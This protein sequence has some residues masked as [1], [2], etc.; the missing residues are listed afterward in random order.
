MFPLITQT[1]REKLLKE[2]SGVGTNMKL[3]K[4][5]DILASE[6][7][8]VFDH[9]FDG[10]CTCANIVGEGF[11][12]HVHCWRSNCDICTYSGI[13][14]SGSIS[15]DLKYKLAEHIFDCSNWKDLTDFNIVVT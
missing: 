11:H 9:D 10:S 1:G 2:T 6:N 15:K 5:Q 12:I 3:P 8:V 7:P 14:V 4:P 13:H